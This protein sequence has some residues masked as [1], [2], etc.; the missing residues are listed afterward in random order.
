MQR[1]KIALLALFLAPAV[2]AAEPKQ[3]IADAWFA[4]N[5]VLVMLGAGDKVVATVAKPTALPWMFKVAPGLSRAQPIEG[6]TMNA[7]ELLRLRTDVVFV[8]PADPTAA[9]LANAGLD[10]VKV[11]FNTI[12]SFVACLQLTADTLATPYAHQQVA[13]YQRYLTETLADVSTHLPA[14]KPTVLHIN[15]LSPLKVDGGKTIID[16]WITAAG[17]RNATTGL[18]GNMQPVSIE[19]VL[20]WNP[21]VIIIGPGAGDL[22]SSPQAGLWNQLAAVREGRV[23]HN[24]A[25]VFPWDRYGPELPLQ[26]RWAKQ[27]IHGG[28]VDEKDMAARTK[29]F[30]KTFYAYD[31]SDGDALRILHGV[32]P[33]G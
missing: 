18:D 21:Q 32:P 7:E 8:T 33:G 5:A 1:L 25:G 16:Q 13:A 29:A 30:Y 27:V 14:D 17:G 31:L 10:V 23:Y 3:R 26:V 20:A 15:S 2:Q 24:P 4:H 9:A 22:A 12:D 28:K 19:Q 11:S 6:G